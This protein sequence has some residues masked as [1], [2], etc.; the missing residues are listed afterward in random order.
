MIQK[1]ILVLAVLV[2]TSFGMSLSKLNSASKDDLMQ[3]NGIGEK[4]AAAIIKERRKGKF[5]SYEDLASR[6]GGIGAQTA[7]NIKND[8]KIGQKPAKVKKAK[9]SVSKKT[10]HK[11]DDAKKKLKKSKSKAKPQTVKKPKTKKVTK[12]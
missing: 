1:L 6:V 3:I 11:K 12:K 7:A 9:K 4:K 2:S 10:S 8:V 5:K